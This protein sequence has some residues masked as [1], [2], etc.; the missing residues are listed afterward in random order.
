M[1][2][3]SLVLLL[4]ETYSQPSGTLVQLIGYSR[5][6][7]PLLP[8]DPIV[9]RKALTIASV[10]QSMYRVGIDLVGFSILT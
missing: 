1:T 6:N 8:S 9:T 10:I 3:D 5:D 4:S 7:R 2:N